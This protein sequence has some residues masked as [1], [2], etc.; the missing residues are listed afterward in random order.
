[1]TPRTALACLALLGLGM[2]LARPG[3]AAP[4]G[5]VL[6]LGACGA[7]GDALASGLPPHGTR[8]L[9]SSRGTGAPADP[10]PGLRL[11]AG[12]ISG[13]P[14]SGATMRRLPGLETP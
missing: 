13:V 5:A 1:M 14:P 7:A 2:V 6:F 10:D 12:L 8:A 9:S 3:Q 11:L 4:I